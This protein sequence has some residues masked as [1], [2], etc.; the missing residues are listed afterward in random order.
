[1]NNNDSELSVE[2]L[3]S[4]D[5]NELGSRKY[6][7]KKDDDFIKQLPEVEELKRQKILKEFMMTTSFT[8]SVRGSITTQAGASVKAGR[9]M[10]QTTF[11]FF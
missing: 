7:E 1:M 11:N 10:R 9:L 4:E 5:K 3:R 2:N 8:I 6:L